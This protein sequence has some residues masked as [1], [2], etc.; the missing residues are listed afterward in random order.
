[1]TKRVALLLLSTFIAFHAPWRVMA[2]VVEAE[3]MK[4]GPV[5]FTQTTDHYWDCA[6]LE[7][8]LSNIG[9]SV[10]YRPN[11]RALGGPVYGYTNSHTHEIVVDANLSWDARYAVLAHEAGHV[12]QPWWLDGGQPEVF[13]EMV[14]TIMSRDGIREHARYLAD[15]KLDVLVV[16]LAEW[17]AAY[18]AAAALEDR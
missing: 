6:Y 16:A 12:L 15:Q 8:R 17:P 9:Y 18:H 4:P 14:S 10:A 11:L 3:F 13:A 5:R 1:M 2:L 7:R